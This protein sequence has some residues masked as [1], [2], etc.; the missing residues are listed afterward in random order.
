MRGLPILNERL[1]V[2]VV[3]RLARSGDWIGVLVTPWCMNLVAMPADPVAGD[4]DPSWSPGIT[5][6]LDLPAGRISLAVA[7][8][9]ALGPY[10]SCPLISPM[11][12]FP[13]QA[14]ALAMARSTLDAFFVPETAPATESGPGISRRALLR[15]SFYGRG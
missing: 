13:D 2:A 4:A 10:A 14:S 1:E 7:I 9:P 5:R 15:G 12:D 6:A 3:E 11:W 8:E